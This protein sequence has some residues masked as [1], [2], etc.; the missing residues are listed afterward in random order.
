MSATSSTDAPSEDEVDVIVL[1]NRADREDGLREA[2]VRGPFEVALREALA[3][4][5]DGWAFEQVLSGVL[6][7]R[8]ARGEPGEW[9]DQF[10]STRTIR[11][12]VRPLVGPGATRPP[13][14]VAGIPGL[15]IPADL[16]AAATA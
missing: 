10:S 5:C 2:K 12:I 13:R 6:S 16:Q 3:Q 4:R 8:P 11:V 14:K 7:R 1:T 15:Y 9:Y